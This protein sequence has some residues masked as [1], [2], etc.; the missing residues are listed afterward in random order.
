M[1]EQESENSASKKMWKVF[2]KE[3]LAL[4]SI[5]IRNVPIGVRA[6]INEALLVQIQFVEKKNEF[7]DIPC[8]LLHKR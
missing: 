2:A 5:C 8:S 3:S 1:Q 6:W 4:K 7:N